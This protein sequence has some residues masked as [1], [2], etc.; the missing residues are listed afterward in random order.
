MAWSTPVFEEVKMD[1]EARGYGSWVGE[2]DPR[3]DRELATPKPSTAGPPA[4][5]RADLAARG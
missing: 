1:A 3:D 2:V 5:A 4:E